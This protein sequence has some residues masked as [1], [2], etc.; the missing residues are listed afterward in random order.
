MFPYVQT[1][2]TADGTQ[3][4]SRQ[5]LSMKERGFLVKRTDGEP[6]IFSPG[7]GDAAGWGVAAL[8]FTNPEFVLYMKE[9][10]KRL[11]K[12]GV[13]V[14]KTD[15]SEEVPEDAVFWDGSTGKEA[16]NLSLIHI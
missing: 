16:H 12:M 15:F 5:Y 3:R 14:I 1:K 9:R 10:V 2:I 13:G 7:E 4:V 6:Y 11:M 8:D